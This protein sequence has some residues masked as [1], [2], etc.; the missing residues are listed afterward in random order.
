MYTI[1]WN[2]GVDVPLRCRELDTVAFEKGL[3]T[4]TNRLNLLLEAAYTRGL[5]LIFSPREHMRKTWNQ[6]G[7]LSS[8]ARNHTAITIT[9]T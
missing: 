6:L 8:A 3:I 7:G 5:Q 2:Y 4:A 1:Y 9:G